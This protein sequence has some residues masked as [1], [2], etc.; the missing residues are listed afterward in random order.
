MSLTLMVPRGSGKEFG[1][2]VWVRSKGLVIRHVWEVVL[3]VWSVLG[4]IE[5]LLPVL[6]P[7]RL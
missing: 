3:G 1:Q 5:M 6:A 2:M 7:L 4:L